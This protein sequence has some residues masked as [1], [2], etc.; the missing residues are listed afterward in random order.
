MLFRSVLYL[1]LLQCLGERPLGMHVAAL[2]AVMEQFRPE[3]AGR[4]VLLL[5]KGPRAGLAALCFAAV[6]PH[7]HRLEIIETPASLHEFIAGDAVVDVGPELFSFGLLKE[8]DVDRLAALIAP[9]PV[10]FRGLSDVQKKRLAPLREHYRAL[11]SDHDP[12]PD[13]KPKSA[14]TKRN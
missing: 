7:V 8:F 2:R 12:L 6:Y 4:D 10:L 1:L 3:L 9:R 13:D 14:A 11:G 5:A